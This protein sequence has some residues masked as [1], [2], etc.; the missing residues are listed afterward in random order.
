MRGRKIVGHACIT[1]IWTVAAHCYIAL[2]S[3]YNQLQNIAVSIVT[4]ARKFYR[5]VTTLLNKAACLASF[6]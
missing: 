6:G 5:H 3:D 1:R 2:H 4:R